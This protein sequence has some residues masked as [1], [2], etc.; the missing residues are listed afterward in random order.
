MNFEIPI[1]V[2]RRKEGQRGSLHYV[3]P[4]FFDLP[5]GR[6]R[7][8]GKATSRL[9]QQLRDHL[10]ELAVIGDHRTMAHYTFAP[11][12]A[13]HW[14]DLRLD[15]KSGMQR[16]KTA[17]GTF[18]QHG[19]LIAFSPY[20]RDLWFEIANKTELAERAGAV[21]TRYFRDLESR[22]E[23]ARIER[24]LR[25]LQLTK[26]PWLTVLE[27]D[28]N[29]RTGGRRLADRAMAF[30]GSEESAD[31]ASELR[32]VGRL[33]SSLY[34]DDLER[35]VYREELVQRL[36][37]LLK[38]TRNRP[39]LL[40]GNALVGK[41][42]LVH[43][44][45]FRELQAVQRQLPQE[46]TAAR[47]IWQITPQRIVTGMSFVGQWE[48]R[49][50]AILR[51]MRKKHYVMFL[52][53]LLGLYQAG[54]TS[55]S[56]L[57]AADVLKPFVDR[58]EVRVVAEMTP[59]QLR[60]LRERDRGFADLFHILP[61]DEPDEQRTLKIQISVMRLLETRFG[62]R[63]DLEVL[64]TVLDLVRR[65]QPEVSFPG[66]AAVWLHQLAVKYQGQ[67]V[68]R[69]D[70]I[71][72]FHLQSGLKLAF[73]DN[74]QQLRRE[75][76]IEG[77]QRRIVG[78]Q[79]AVEAM[80]DVVSIA[81]AR[82]NDPGRPLGSLF[83]LGPTGVGKTECCKA[84][85]AYLFS[86]DTRLVRFD[87]NEFVS[88]DSPARFVGTFA[89]P[90]GLLT[91]AVRH[92][93][94]CVLL[95]DEI[96]KA[97]P[98]V[99]D[100]LLQ[101]LGEARLTQA[102]GRTV[103]FANTVIILTSN[104][105]TREAARELGFGP[106]DDA[107]AANTYQRAVQEFFRPEFFNR[108]DRIVP[109]R[110][111]DRDEMQRIAHVMVDQATGRQGLLRRK[112]IVDISAA[113]LESIVR[114]GYDPV[115]GARAMRRA[116]EQELVSPLARQLAGVLPETPTVLEVSC[117][118]TDVVGTSSPGTVAGGPSAQAEPVP[119][120]RLSVQVT[121]LAQSEPWPETGAGR[122]RLLAI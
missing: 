15:L 70:V 27:L 67:D 38:D 49:W 83:F 59:E 63:F 17:F 53:D 30:L 115:L 81:K 50:L 60:V 112:C 74:R 37:D 121:A 82:L 62:V 92:Q 13:L 21:L 94:F 56:N 4:V 117:L 89:Q 16:C 109:F 71:R 85:A 64:S 45:V 72:E 84:L 119:R 118:G 42:T 77:L 14:L 2:E 110:R 22:Q 68:T 108:L 12:V 43:E 104:L 48:D 69:D 105:G 23:R 10:R 103:S 24:E 120:G 3:R 20:L 88:P 54:I 102:Q 36:S 51:H 73:V 11:H 34:P 98:D 6:G 100:L 8:L 78:Q 52:D 7:D 122:S 106:S 55:Q 35:A 86:D 18:T 25:W 116:V 91:A 111:L 65:Y 41:T 66:K 97:H 95:F 107:S 58:G 79:E 96:E 28:I 93:P 19:R 32:R 90:E 40:V 47:H 114:R 9:E 29:T 44:T 39:I 57:C 87:M 26:K 80:A 31:G 75:E 5:E 1:L 113:A 99:F 61:V 46:K 101:I 33:L 76:V